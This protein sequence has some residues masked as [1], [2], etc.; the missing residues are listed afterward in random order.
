MPLGKLDLNFPLHCATLCALQLMNGKVSS[1]YLNPIPYFMYTS[2]LLEFG[3][4]LCQPYSTQ[5]STQ[6]WDIQIDVPPGARLESR[7]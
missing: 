6:K 5:S 4:S 2:P 1:L 7:H 3:C